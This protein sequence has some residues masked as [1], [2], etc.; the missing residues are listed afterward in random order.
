MAIYSGNREIE[1]YFLFKEA[2]WKDVVTSGQ[3]INAHIVDARCC[4]MTNAWS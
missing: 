4:P 1:G 2:L 3:D